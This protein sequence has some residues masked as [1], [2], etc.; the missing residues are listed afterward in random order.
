MKDILNQLIEHKAL[1]KETAKELEEV[2]QLLAVDSQAVQ[3]P[4]RGFGT[5]VTALPDDLAV[6]VPDALGGELADRSRGSRSVRLVTEW[7][8]EETLPVGQKRFVPSGIQKLY[9][10]S[11]LELLVAIQKL[12]QGIEVGA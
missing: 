10:L 6:A 8:A 3:G 7:L 1:G 9:E 4:G 11:M 5:D 2:A 12:A